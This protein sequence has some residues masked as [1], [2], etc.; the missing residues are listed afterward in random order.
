MNQISM[1]PVAQTGEETDNPLLAETEQRLQRLADGYDH[2]DVWQF[3]SDQARGE[4]GELLLDTLRAGFGAFGH[5]DARIRNLALCVLIAARGDVPLAL[6]ALRQLE[7][8]DASCPQV[9]G[10]YF[11]VSRMDDPDRSADLSDRFCAAPFT[12]FETLIDGTVAPCCSIWTKKR[13]GHLE[14]QNAEEIWNS[15]DAQDMRASIL[16]GSFR[17]CNKQRCTLIMEDQLPKRSEIEDETLKAIIDEEKT[18]LDSSPSWL[19]LAHDITCNLACP[20]CRAGM[21]VADEAQEKRFEKIEREVFFPLLGSDDKI[22]VSVSGQGDAWSSQHYRSIFRYLADH[23]TNAELNIHTNALLMGPKRWNEYIGL[24]KYAPLV[25]VSIDAATPWVYEYVRQ[26]GKWERLEPNLRFIADKRRKGIFREFHLNAT[27]QMDNFHEIPALIDLAGDLSADSMRLYMM[28]NTGGHL[29][30]DFK[31][32][33]IAD[34]QHPMHLAFL[35]TLRD[36]RLALPFTHMYDVAG[37]RETALRRKLPSDTLGEDWS[38]EDALERIVTLSGGNNAGEIAAVCT[39]A[40]IRYP[41]RVEF[42]IM[43]AMALKALGFERAA[44]YRE[45]MAEALTSGQAA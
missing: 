21:I 28:Q 44:G 45:K 34:E 30:R 13:L 41:E 3:L 20:S 37:W 10:A 1:P 16:D 6:K 36:P 35:E 22:T 42:L 32:K 43:E 31:T 23:D 27:I 14:R 26:P 38:A 15:E 9:A 39:A 33:N 4:T 25:D 29:A 18:S 19:F 7:A 24:E 17:H 40:R 8:R 5:A 2:P 12:K 11:F